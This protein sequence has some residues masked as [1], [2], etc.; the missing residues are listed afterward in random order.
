VAVADILEQSDCYHEQSGDKPAERR[1]RAV[2]SA[3]LRIVESPSAGALHIRRIR[4]RNIANAAPPEEV[5]AR[6]W[7][8][9]L[10]HRERLMFRGIAEAGSGLDQRP[11]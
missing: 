6:S 7:D 3:V 5:S 4:V 11:P 9:I 2:T 8:E 10:Q 1:E